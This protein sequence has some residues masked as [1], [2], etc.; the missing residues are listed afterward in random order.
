[1]GILELIPS[2]SVLVYSAVVVY[3]GSIAY[4][5]LVWGSSLCSPLNGDKNVPK[6]EW[7]PGGAEP[8]QWGLNSLIG[9]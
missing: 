5:A 1:M 3:I 6:G 9:I 7:S 2:K 4:G 8:A